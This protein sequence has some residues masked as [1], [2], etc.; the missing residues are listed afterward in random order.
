MTSRVDL[1]THSTASDGTYLPSELAG[2]A[3]EIGLSAIALT[4]HDNND[5]IGE[6]MEECG[7]L[8]VEGIPGIEIST[9]YEKQLHIVGLYNSGAEFDETVK[10][11]KN[12]RAERNEKMFEKIREYGFDITRE[13]ILENGK[14]TI[15]HAGRLHMANA[16]VRKGYAADKN[17]AFDRF[18]MRGRPCYVEKFSLSPEE[19]V[20][21]IKRCGGIAI[22]AHPAL[23]MDNEADML[24]MA[25]SLKAA[26]LDAME[27][28]YSTYTEEMSRMCKAV[29]QKT[30]LLT[31]GGSD[32][33]GMNKPDVK[34][35]AVSEGIV[36]YEI[37]EKLKQRIG[38]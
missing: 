10:R 8:G 34:L 11:L 28:Y 17:E 24:E 5:G 30:G 18:L 32:F 23:A 12:A 7:R 27:C 20:K 19:S 21:L 36:P 35:G 6:F 22:W 3:K 9:D 37:L 29:A 4:D 15:E 26:G 13:D 2:L 31:S 25:E 38:I 16:L 33:H 1:H 14:V